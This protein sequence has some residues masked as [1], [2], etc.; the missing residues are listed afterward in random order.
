MIDSSKNSSTSI[1]FALRHFL[2]SKVK[3]NATCPISSDTFNHYYS[4]IG[5][6]L[7][8]NINIQDIQP[9]T[10]NSDFLS[11]NISDVNVNF[12][13]YELL[14]L[15]HK[16]SLDI[17]D[18]DPKLP[19]VSSLI[20]APLLTHIVNLSLAQG[21]IPKDLKLAR[22]T[23]IYKGKGDLDDPSNY[24]PISVISYLAKIHEKAVKS[25]ITILI[26]VK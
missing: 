24:H 19:R 3:E 21:F 22:I 4:T 23:P 12:V 14:K 6:K 16:A 13:L 18:M 11:F 17:M 7:E 26:M 9:A 2:P 1:W 8:K 10:S 25:V 20:I 15:P 5:S